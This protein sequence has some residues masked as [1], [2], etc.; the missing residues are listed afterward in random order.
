MTI[1]VDDKK[2]FEVELNT[3]SPN[4]CSPKFPDGSPFG[5]IIAA[6]KR[7]SF[8]YGKTVGEHGKMMSVPICGTVFMDIP[9]PPTDELMVF[10]VM[11]TVTGD[12][13]EKPIVDLD[14][15]PDEPF[16]EEDQFPSPEE[17]EDLSVISYFNYDLLDYIKLS[18]NPGIYNVKVLWRGKQSNTVTIEIYEKK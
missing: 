4:E 7:V 2:F 17:L 11:D 3:N 1:N 6:P 9:S 13:Y 14:E 16:P 12:I 10:H 5:I 18:S 8:E 15:S